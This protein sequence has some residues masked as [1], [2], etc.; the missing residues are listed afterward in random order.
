MP[1][2]NEMSIPD[3]SAIVLWLLSGCFLV[4]SMVVVG[5]I[6]RLT[7]SGLSI[8]KWDVV[9]GTLPPMNEADWQ[10]EFDHYKQTPQFQH[11]NAHFELSD[12]KGIYWWEYIHRLL[13]RLIGFVFLV[14]FLWFVVRGK[15]KGNLIWKC[16]VLFLLGGLQ[17]F[18]GWY[19][20]KS[21]LVNEP[22]V[23]HFRLA[24]HLCTAFTTFCVTLWFAMD[25]VNSERITLTGWKRRL[26]H[27]VKLVLGITFVQI[28]FGAFVAGLK[29]GLIYNTW[30]LMGDSFV[31]DSFYF[32][33]EKLG[34]H[35]LI[36]NM[37]GVQFVHRNVAYLVFFGV[38]GL[39]FFVLSN[40]RK[41]NMHLLPGQMHAL[42]ICVGL[43]CLQFVLGVFT[44]LHAV[45]LVLGVIHQAGALLLLGS[46]VYLLHRLNH[47]SV[48]EKNEHQ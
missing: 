8:T 13:G 1:R 5:G 12:F 14:P 32:A 37:S 26:N 21:G 38:L 11:I 47:V 29:A 7:G 20:V 41:G 36:D 27:F 33:W 17:G 40:H 18:L 30:P 23:S 45:P 10:K 24:L 2:L 25:L 39:L 22:S 19:M 42:W 34:W 4:F 35:A 46:L 31:P 9:T 6:T 16:M 3:R 48:P 44:L 43:V 28:I 15:I